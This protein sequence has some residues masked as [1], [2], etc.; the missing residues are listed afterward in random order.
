[1]RFS[2]GWNPRHAEGLMNSILRHQELN[3][4]HD[5]ENC[6]YCRETLLRIAVN[7]GKWDF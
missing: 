6:S 7:V 2:I 4:P 3:C 5:C 1:M